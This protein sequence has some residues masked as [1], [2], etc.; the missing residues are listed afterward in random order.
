MNILFLSH[1]IPFP[2]NKGEKI[3]TF[4]QLKFLVEKGHNVSVIAPY[5]DDNEL[6]H[7]DALGQN[8]CQIVKGVKLTSKV[9][10]LAK[11]VIKGKALSIAN[12]YSDELQ[13]QLDHLITG[14][15]FDT[16][17]CTASSMAEYVFKSEP[18]QQ[19]GNL[20]L[21]MDF[22]DLDSDKWQQYAQNAAFPM[23]WVYRREATLI[24]AFE[25]RISEYFNACFF[26]TEAEK[27]LFAKTIG[28]VDNIFAVENGIDT[29]MFKPSSSEQKSSRERHESPV[30]LFTGVMDYAPNVDAVVWFVENVWPQVTKKW[31][32]AEFY[33]AGMS[34][35]DK[36]KALANHQGV[37]IT[38][39]VDDILPYFDKATVFVGPFRIARG[40]QNKILQA[41]ACGL[42][43]IATSM[44]A[45]GIHCKD[46]ESILLAQSPDEFIQQLTRLLVE[47][48]LYEK[49]SENA[50]Q[51]IFDYYAWDSVLAPFE[52]VLNNEVNTQQRN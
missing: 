27:T 24:G 28:A 20:T 8:Y 13:T 44:G 18:I 25:K 5:E 19:K 1:R 39:Y 10:R 16:I 47:P 31:S 43:V 45:E 4:H 35:S 11:G 22:M 40:V 32:K 15:T 7:F 6:A 38:G 48:E 50:L 23:S 3:R 30:L 21:L 9:I 29:A 34:P 42:P 33:I 36:V 26:I 46:E 14:N 51:N 41:F 49:V 52:R 37:V 17:I 12:F 2:P